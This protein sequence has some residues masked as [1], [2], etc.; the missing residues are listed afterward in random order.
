[1]L[2]DFG[3]IRSIL[4][5]G[6]TKETFDRPYLKVDHSRPSVESLPLYAGSVRCAQ[7][8]FACTLGPIGNFFVWRLQGVITFTSNGDLEL[9][10]RS[11]YKRA[12]VQ[13]PE[14][15]LQ[16]EMKIEFPNLMGILY[17]QYIS[18]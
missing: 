15:G 8:Q 4:V 10:A 18:E 12:L 1:M 6:T 7:L 11:P 16:P 9:L 3:H 14:G 5:H 2:S 17:H 13:C